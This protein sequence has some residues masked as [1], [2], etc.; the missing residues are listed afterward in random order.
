MSAGE[1]ARRVA[2]G[3]TVALAGFLAREACLA[4]MPAPAPSEPPAAPAKVERRESLFTDEDDLNSPPTAPPEVIAEGG[5]AR[6]ISIWGDY[7]LWSSGEGIHRVSAWGGGPSRLVVADRSVSDLANDGEHIYWIGSGSASPPWYDILRVPIGGGRAQEIARGGCNPLGLLVD[8]AHVYFAGLCDGI[9]RVPKRGGPSKTLLAFDPNVSTRY[10][11]Q[12]EA[13]IYWTDEAGVSSVPK[14]GGAPR[15]ILKAQWA[16]AIAVDRT[17]IY[18][19]EGSCGSDCVPHAAV[20][21]RLAK[22]GGVVSTLAERQVYVS[23]IALDATHVYWRTELGS[24]R[25]ALKEGGPVETLARNQGS[26]DSLEAGTR[27]VYW[28]FRLLAS[29]APPHGGVARVPR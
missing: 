28:S 12:D 21:R 22:T 1:A 3:A 17:H 11:A 9:Q 2:A 16:N 13:N 7:V 25:R 15:L 29:G 5:S 14:A 24:I 18:W 10:I 20:V 26:G 23:A 8:E 27:H 6:D 4:D 19:S